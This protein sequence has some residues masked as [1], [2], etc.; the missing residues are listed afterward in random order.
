MMFQWLPCLHNTTDEEG[1]VQEISTSTE[2][3][4]VSANASP[5]AN[6]DAL[7]GDCSICLQALS[8]AADTFALDCT[9]KFHARCILEWFIRRHHFKCPLCQR[10]SFGTALNVFGNLGRRSNRVVPPGSRA[11]LGFIITQSWAPAFVAGGAAV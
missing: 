4:Y 2:D 10:E 6:P 5:E 3:E 11:P 1:S 8:S 7:D 9:H